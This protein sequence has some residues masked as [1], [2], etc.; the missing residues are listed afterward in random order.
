MEIRA[1]RYFVTIVQ[2]EGITAA[3][4][5][6][7]VSQ[8]TLSRRIGD[9][10]DELGAKLFT[11]GN[12]GHTLELT[13]EGRMLYRR[14]CEI[15]A[16][17]DKAEA[18]IATSETVEG[19]LHISA[20]Q[21]CSMRIVAKALAAL[22][23]RHPGVV[24]HLQD[25]YSDDIIDRLNNGL[26]D[27]GLLV[28]PVDMSGF[29][30]LDIPGLDP[31]GVVVREDHPLAGRASVD[32]GELKDIRA[33]VPK[34][35]ISRNDALIQ[36]RRLTDGLR[37]IGT[38]NL[39]HNAGYLVREGFGAMVCPESVAETGEGSGL[40]FVP[41]S[42]EHVVRVSLAWKKNQPLSRQA[43]VFLSLLRDVIDGESSGDA[44]DTV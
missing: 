29:D 14:A 44:D 17:A 21:T 32:V 34:G 8:P 6:L 12:R 20:A 11:R 42:P 9:L 24:V 13:R 38:M 22:C 39:A 26:T 4:D 28:Q 10:E 43:E 23:E 31:L 30:Y 2:E 5:M 27:F 18:E 16:L 33:I 40:A 3:A 36:S 37:M 19:D 1:L 7:R 35:S 15:I 41:V 25:A